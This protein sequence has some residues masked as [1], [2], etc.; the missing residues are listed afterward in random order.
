MRV[1]EGRRVRARPRVTCPGPSARSD[2]ASIALKGTEAGPVLI[3][4]E[5]R[6]RKGM[7][8]SEYLNKQRE[9]NVNR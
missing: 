4:E 8:L 5:P 3:E 7:S 9:Q 2:A 6:Q 1:G